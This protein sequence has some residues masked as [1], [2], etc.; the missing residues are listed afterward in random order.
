M[1]SLW[2]GPS[3]QGNIEMALVNDEDS[4]VLKKLATS[5]SPQGSSDSKQ[6]SAAK[7]PLMGF[8]L[9]NASSDLLLA[10][11]LQDFLRMLSNDDLDIITERFPLLPFVLDGSIQG[12]AGVELLDAEELE[13]C[14]PLLEETISENN[15]NVDQAE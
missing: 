13:Q 11:Q 3:Q 9:V 8:R 10:K 15:L 7:K 5:W 6:G 4:A 12:D 1:K 2:H 14:D